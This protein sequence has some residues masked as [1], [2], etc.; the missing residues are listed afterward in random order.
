V[1]CSHPVHRGGYMAFRTLGGSVLTCSVHAWV[2]ARW[3]PP[4]GCRGGDGC[5]VLGA[6]GVVPAPGDFGLEELWPHP[7]LNGQPGSSCCP[8]RGDHRVA[9][10]IAG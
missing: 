1:V 7:S 3:S 4:G 5:R 8:P 2:L 10:D 9:S 6:G